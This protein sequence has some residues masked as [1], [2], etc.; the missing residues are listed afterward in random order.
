MSNH[1]EECRDRSCPGC[2]YNSTLLKLKKELSLE[3]QRHTTMIGV[4]NEVG[5]KLTEAEEQL[6]QWK[7][8]YCKMVEIRDKFVERIAEL[9]AGIKDALEINRH[10]Q[11]MIDKAGLT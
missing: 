10:L 6:E 5:R 2:G 9:E 7:D 3:Q 8:Q 1:K 4:A 11:E